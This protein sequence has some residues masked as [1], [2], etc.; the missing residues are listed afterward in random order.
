M[1]LIDVG[2]SGPQEIDLTTFPPTETLVPG[3]TLAP[4]APENHQ[5]NGWCPRRNASTS[6]GRLR[7]LGILPT[8]SHDSPPHLPQA[9]GEEG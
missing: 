3:Q 2:G 7:Y 1:I 8:P 4:R 6:T 5:G 9:L